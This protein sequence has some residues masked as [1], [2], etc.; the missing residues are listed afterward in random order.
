MLPAARSLLILLALA[1]GAVGALLPCPAASGPAPPRLPMARYYDRAGV[2]RLASEGDRLPAGSYRLTLWAARGTPLRGTLGAAPFATSVP[3]GPGEADWSLPVDVAV[4]AETTRLAVDAE[5]LATIGYLALLPAESAR[6]PADWLACIRLQPHSLQP[7]GAARIA[8]VRDNNQGIDFHP[9]STL[10]EW[11]ARRAEIRRQILVSAGLWPPWPRTDLRPQVFGRI[12]RDGYTIEKVALETLPGFYLT[13]NLYRPRPGGGRLPGVLCPHGHWSNHRFEPD[14]QARCIGLAR[15][16]AVVFL[17]DMVGY[18]DSAPFGHQFASSEGTLLGVNLLGLQL[19]NSIRAL[20]FLLSLPEVDSE[21]IGCTG[22]SGGGTQTFLLGAVD[23]RVRVAAPAVMVSEYFQ[24]GCQCENS[25]LLRI[26]TDN[27]EITACFA[28]RP[29]LLIGATGDWTRNTL[30]EVLPRIRGV[31]RLYGAGDRVHAELFPYPHNYN[32]DSR[33]AMYTFFARHLFGRTGAGRVEEPPFTPESRATLAVWGGERPRPADAADATALR[34]TLAAV[35]ERQIA[36]LL[37]RAREQWQRARATLLDG[38]RVTLGW[39]EPEWTPASGER[40]ARV[41]G[42]GWEAEA[43]RLDRASGEHPVPATLYRPRNRAP[44]SAVLIAHPAGRAGVLAP[45]G[46]PG[47]LLAEVLRAGWAALVIDPYLTGEYLAPFGP[48]Q[49][50]LVGH[51]WTYNRSPLAERVG[52]LILAARWLAGPARMRRTMLIGVGEAGPW[53]LLALPFLPGVDAVVDAHR[54]EFP[55]AM[56]ESDPMFL[57]H[58]R[59]YG[60]LR[61]VLALAA[62]RRLLLTNLGSLDTAPARAAYRLMD[63][64]RHLRLQPDASRAEAIAWLKSR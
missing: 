18:G 60:G 38:L 35:I 43:W 30:S 11:E 62:P 27:I 19:W 16:G 3:P 47:P 13:G 31:Y 45:D 29:L 57:P 37:P 2:L 54:Y 50:R 40:L 53:S 58:A 41:A 42:G 46:E 21:R 55:A 26:G 25:P 56:A 23:D 24:G 51:H 61:M 17:Y 15:M 14:V 39:R 64:S 7:F 5:T 34:Q 12:E 32:R 49:R 8:T 10:A 33:Q 36:D 1:A 4:T 9:P 52:D 20:D 59:R 63:A 44:R 48:P 6:H 28:P 22:A